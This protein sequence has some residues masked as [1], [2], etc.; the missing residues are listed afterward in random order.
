VAVEL[1]HKLLGVVVEVAPDARLLGARSGR[2]GEAAAVLVVTAASMGWRSS[3][4]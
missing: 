3:T 1:V 2:D 4:A